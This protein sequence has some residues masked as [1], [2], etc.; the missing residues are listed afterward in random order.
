MRPTAVPGCLKPARGAVVT[1]SPSPDSATAPFESAPLITSQN[2][3][4]A[5]S[6]KQQPFS[7]LGICNQ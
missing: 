5:N 1:P 2:V 3:T 4:R 7:E 6:K